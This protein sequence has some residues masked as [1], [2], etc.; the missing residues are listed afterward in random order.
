VQ[1]KAVGLL[2]LLGLSADGLR[3]RPA[4]IPKL[5][6]CW[7]R[8]PQLTCGTMP[9]TRCASPTPVAGLNDEGIV[10]VIVP[11]LVWCARCQ[12]LPSGDGGAVRTALTASP[13]PSAR[14]LS[15]RFLCLQTISRTSSSTAGSR[16]GRRK[17]LPRCACP[18]LRVA[19][20]RAGGVGGPLAPHTQAG[21]QGLRRQPKHVLCVG[22]VVHVQT[23]TRMG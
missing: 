1:L 5:F 3:R 20:C 16:L 8:A 15:S 17:R 6:G 4:A 9:Q 12:A 18:L 14:S 2:G 11:A 10:Y 23:V 13:T 22:C 21:P 19:W 7:G